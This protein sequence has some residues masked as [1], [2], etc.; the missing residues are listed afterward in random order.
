MG[1]SFL[2]RLRRAFPLIKKVVVD[3]IYNCLITGIWV[4]TGS[5]LNIIRKPVTIGISSCLR[6][7]D[8]S[9]RI[10]QGSREKIIVYEEGCLITVPLLS[11]CQCHI[12]KS[13]VGGA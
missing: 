8:C 12:D 11:L 1:S 5:D 13:W 2:Q 3:C 7:F 4:H 6:G 9:I 10:K